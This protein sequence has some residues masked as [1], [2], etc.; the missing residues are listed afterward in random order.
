MPGMRNPRVFD[1][2]DR[3]YIQP[4]IETTEMG[5]GSLVED[6]KKSICQR[7]DGEVNLGI[8]DWF[9]NNRKPIITVLAIY[10]GY[11]LLRR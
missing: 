10:G 7:L 9:R 1:S 6:D 3:M 4:D 5:E 11:R 2:E 8:A